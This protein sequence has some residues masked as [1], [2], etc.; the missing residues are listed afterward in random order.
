MKTLKINHLA[1]VV[2]IVASQVI[3]VLWYAI[4][5][6]EWM[7]MSN[8]TAEQAQAG[9][10]MPYI[11]SVLSSAIMVYVMAWIYTKIPV[12][13]AQNGLT[14]GALLGL[15]FGLLSIVV[16]NMFQMKPLALGLINGGHVFV[17]YVVTG[18]IL[19]AWRKYE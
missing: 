12:E 15:A 1:A 8:L 14:T 7:A 13:S 9:G 3:P 19:G 2:C 18:L 4:F 11:V 10:S 17:V 16:Q 6:N 5:A